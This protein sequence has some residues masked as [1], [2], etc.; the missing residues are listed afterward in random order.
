M[1]TVYIFYIYLTVTYSQMRHIFDITISSLQPI[2][3]IFILQL[4]GDD[5]SP[6]LI[7]KRPD[8][9]EKHI[10]PSIDVIQIIWI[11][12]SQFDV[13]MELVKPK[14]ETAAVSLATDVGARSEW[15]GN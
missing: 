5:I 6:I 12:R 3:P 11:L 10:P 7:Q 9:V 15:K 4:H 14:R 13:R 2:T 1:E 8:F